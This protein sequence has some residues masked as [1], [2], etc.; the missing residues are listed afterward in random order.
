LSAGHSIKCHLSEEQLNE[1]VH[2]DPSAVLAVA[3]DVPL[4]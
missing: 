3:I 4:S 2:I 1:P